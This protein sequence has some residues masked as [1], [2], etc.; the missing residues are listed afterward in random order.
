MSNINLNLKKRGRKPKNY[1]AIIKTEIEKINSEEEKIIYHLP[2]TLNEINN[3]NVDISMFIK[4]KTPSIDTDIND[5][6]R[7]SYSEKNINNSINNINTIITHPLKF[8]SNTKCWW[9]KNT[10]TSPAVHLPEDYFNNIFY[11][12]G[13]FC[14]YNCTKSYNLDLNDSLIYKRESLLNLLYYL[15]YSKYINIT[16]A[17]HWLTLKE[18]GGILSIEEFREQFNNN[19]TE[20]LVLHPPLIS[21]EM[22]IEESYKQI[23]L[24]EVPITK[25]NKLYSDIDSEFAI[26]RN[27]PP[28][29][30]LNLENTMGLKI[31]KN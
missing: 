18:Y 28:N 2:I 26:K 8:D 6:I 16:N 7:S 9:C 4:N 21:R 10:F 29:N 30:Q 24:K 11:C 5:T 19:T 31:N 3:H 12:I 13:N 23:K 25:I 14:S 20:Y 22:Q 17:P 1:N 27:K 15:T